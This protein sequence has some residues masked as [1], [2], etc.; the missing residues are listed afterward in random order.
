MAL[1]AD[2]WDGRTS[3]RH[4]VELSWDP[5]ARRLHIQGLGTRLSY[6]LEAVRIS[7]RVGS[8]P[9]L[10]Q[11]PD[12]ACCESADNDGIDS[13]L[14]RAGTGLRGRL[15]HR[16]ESRLGFAAVALALCVV[17]IWAVLAHGVPGLAA[18]VARQLPTA[19][20][21]AIGQ[22]SLATLDRL[23]LVPSTLAV[24]ERTHVVSLFHA[25]QAQRPAAARAQLLFRGGGAVGANALALPAGQVVVTDE[26]LAL[27]RNEEELLG[28]LAHE[29]GHVVHRHSLR[30]LLESAALATLVA[31]I[32]GDVSSLS[33]VAA[34]LPGLLVRAGYSRDMEREADGYA[35]D[36]LLEQGI[37]PQHYAAMLQRLAGR[38]DPRGGTPAVLASHPPTPERIARFREAA[39]P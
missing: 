19:V 36:Y 1:Q 4:R 26:L 17:V 33:G 30:A 3:A 6:P 12:G 13:L 29:L 23:F 21:D 5:A 10:I 9:R 22:R 34:T 31:A 18:A 32:T 11:L 27:A 39:R 16:L 14:A 15:A 2:Y 28:V 35:L 7:S 8:T 24:E 37:A 25:L 38:D 20:E